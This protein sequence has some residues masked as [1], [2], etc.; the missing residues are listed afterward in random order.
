MFGKKSA[1]GKRTAVESYDKETQ[2]PVIRCSICTG[3]QVAGFKD[4]RTGKF[5]EVMLIKNSKD[6]DT[7]MQR[8][9]L[10]DV[11]KEY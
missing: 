6:M 8:Y 2:K 5:E 1:F 7:F 9:Q 11:S 3:E 10:T 4:I